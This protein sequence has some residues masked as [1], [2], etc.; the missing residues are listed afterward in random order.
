MIERRKVW[1][2]SLLHPRDARGRE[3]R[4]LFFVGVS[5]GLIWLCVVAVIWKFVAG[6]PA[7]TATEFSGVIAGLFAAFAA[8]VAVWLGREWVDAKRSGGDA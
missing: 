2:G 4:T 3:S 5:V 1:W 7:M 8:V 6:D